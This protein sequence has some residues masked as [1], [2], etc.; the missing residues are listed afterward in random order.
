MKIQLKNINTL[1][2]INTTIDIAKSSI[3]NTSSKLKH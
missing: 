1:N 2:V 3:S